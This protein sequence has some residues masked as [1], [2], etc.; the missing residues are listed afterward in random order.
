VLVI[1]PRGD[2]NKNSWW[3]AKESSKKRSKEEFGG[4][5]ERRGKTPILGKEEKDD[6]HGDFEISH[7]A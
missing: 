5:S 3:E 1:Q 6:G 7:Q 4:I 2:Q